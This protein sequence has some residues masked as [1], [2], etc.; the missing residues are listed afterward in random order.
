MGA[1]VVRRRNRIE[2]ACANGEAI[3]RLSRRDEPTVPE[4]AGKRGDDAARTISR[5][6]TLE[7]EAVPKGRNRKLVEDIAGADH[8]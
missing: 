1:P 5:E 7:F 6:R 3:N 8:E 4:N 2:V